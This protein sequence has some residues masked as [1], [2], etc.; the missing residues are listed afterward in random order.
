MLGFPLQQSITELLLDTRLKRQ[1]TD[2]LSNVTRP[3]VALQQSKINVMISRVA[4]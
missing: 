2:V 1:E 4:W 3:H